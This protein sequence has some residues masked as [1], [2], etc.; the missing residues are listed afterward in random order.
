M[1][2]FAVRGFELAMYDPRE[3]KR[4][5]EKSRGKSGGGTLDP[6]SEPL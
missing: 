2:D 4:L 1:E 5:T 6:G 3:Q